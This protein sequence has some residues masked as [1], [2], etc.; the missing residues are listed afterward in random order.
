MLTISLV[1]VARSRRDNASSSFVPLQP[2]HRSHR[3]RGDGGRESG[4]LSRGDTALFS[5]Q[6]PESTHSVKLLD[7]SW[8]WSSRGSDVR[9]AIP[10]YAIL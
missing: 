8:I 10:I 5:M 9:N 1:G 7:E 2:K 3:D 4:G 6:T